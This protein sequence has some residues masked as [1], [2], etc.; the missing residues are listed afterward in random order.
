MAKIPHDLNAPEETETGVP[1]EDHD[2]KLKEEQEDRQRANLLKLKKALARKN[3]LF[4][5]VSKKVKERKKKEAQDINRFG[6]AD[7]GDKKGEKV[8]DA[9]LAA[10]AESNAAHSGA[11][12]T[13]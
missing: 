9:N 4:M 2:A 1:V 12:K 6:R 10:E 3:A 8:E 13:A 7:R 5:E 11:A